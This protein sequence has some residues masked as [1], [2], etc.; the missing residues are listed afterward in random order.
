MIQPSIGTQVGISLL[1]RKVL[2]CIGVCFTM[3]LPAV[4]TS[5]EPAGREM[6][7][8]AEFEAAGT[9]IRQIRISPQNIFDLDDARENN[10][11]FRTAN[12]LHIKTRPQVI[13]K[14]LLFKIGERVSAQKIEETERLLR[15]VR[16][17]YD[18]EIRPLKNDQGTV[19]IEVITRDTWTIDVAGSVSRSGGNNKTSF[20]LKE[21]NLLGT[22]LRLGFSRTSDA[23]RKGTEFEVSYPQ[24]FDGWTNLS[25]SQAHFDDGRRRAAAIVRPFYALDTRWAGGASWNDDDRIDSIYNAGETIGQYRHR[26]KLGEIFGGWSPGLGRGWTQRYLFGARIR[27]HE[28]SAEP[29]RVFPGSAPVLLPVTQDQHAVFLRYDLVEERFVKL[30]NRDQIGR[31]EFFRLGFNSQLQVTRTLAT[32]GSAQ[33]AWLY[34]AL[35]SNGFEFAS[36]RDLLVSAALERRIA[37]SGA[38][39]TQIGG[40]ARYYIPQG[41]NALFYA[42]LSGDRISGGGVAD[43]LLLGGDNGLRGY[44]LR[45][46]AGERRVL[47]SLEERAYTDWY[48]FR[49]LRVGGAAFFDVGRA[50]GGLNQNALNPGWLADVGVGLRIAL[51]RAAFA[52]VLHADIAVPLNRTPDI[53]SVQFL[54][55]TEV[56]F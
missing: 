31:P 10:W 23:D 48:P 25:Y 6:P 15:N 53:K 51:D 26:Q 42:S 13:E 16:F 35:V 18:V 5:A 19:D 28:Y 54:V 56:T 44:K 17:I 47:L 55:K 49:L 2:A 45:Y 34:S 21:Y 30:K 32:R 43:Q 3:A 7:T 4:A 27:D 9:V 36:R 52:N 40:V 50:W 33:S 37:T 39:M 38:P 24:A 41:R 8:F 29:S 11:L 22:G 1:D 14:I 20:G 12:S 46:Q